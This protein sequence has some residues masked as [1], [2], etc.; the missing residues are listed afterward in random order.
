MPTRRVPGRPN[1]YRWGQSG[2][3]YC[4]P[5]AKA[6]ADRQGRA[7]HASGY[8]AESPNMVKQR[9][10]LR[11]AKWS[12]LE[13]G[14]W[15]NK[16]GDVV[17]TTETWKWVDFAVQF[18]TKPSLH[19]EGR[20]GPMKKLLQDSVRVDDTSDGKAAWKLETGLLDDI[21][22]FFE[23]EYGL[24]EVV[25]DHST[26]GTMQVDFFSNPDD[27]K[28]YRRLLDEADEKGE[29]MS[30]DEALDQL[31]YWLEE[32][33]WQSDGAFYIIADDVPAANYQR[34]QA[35]SKS[36]GLSRKDIT[37][38]GIGA[39]TGIVAGVL[40]EF[41]SEILVDRLRKEPQLEITD[42]EQPENS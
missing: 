14:L 40:G 26:D 24:P 35:E 12:A 23:D 7:I 15:Q 11:P 2:K 36:L 18:K 42:E 3:I 28:K 17:K 19:P 38:L 41:V 32:T 5:G 8:R 20:V 29:S 30:D 6:K 39:L 22:W 37:L 4:G 25:F 16:S 21:Y 9:W 13:V 33:E 1:C 10:I 31:G 34:F 27:L